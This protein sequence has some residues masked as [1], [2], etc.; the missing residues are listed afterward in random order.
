MGTSI[1]KKIEERTVNG[2]TV[3]DVVSHSKIG[4]SK[5][6]ILYF[7]EFSDGMYAVIDYGRRK[8]VERLADLL[9]L[10]ADIYAR[11]EGELNEAG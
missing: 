6:V 4:A 5:G 11:K 7:A 3:G 2:Y 10:G 9:P 8:R 1:G